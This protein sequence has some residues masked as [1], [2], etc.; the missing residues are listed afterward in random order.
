MAP[1]LEA[2]E[3]GLKS[4]PKDIRSQSLAV[5]QQDLEKAAHLEEKVSHLLCPPLLSL[6]LCLCSLFLSFS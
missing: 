3:L 2:M 1:G 4:F 5:I 6:S